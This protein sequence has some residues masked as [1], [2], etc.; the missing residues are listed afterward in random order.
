[1]VPS[2]V[3]HCSPDHAYSAPMIQ[4]VKLLAFLNEKDLFAEFFKVS[5]FSPGEECLFRWI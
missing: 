4:V 1:M 5:Y 3:F 2:Y